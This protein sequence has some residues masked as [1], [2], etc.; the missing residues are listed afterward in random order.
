M[1]AHQAP[2]QAR[3]IIGKPARNMKREAAACGSINIIIFFLKRRR[4]SKLRLLSKM[5]M[6]E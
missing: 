5:G 2:P 6:K 1:A 3:D 4:I